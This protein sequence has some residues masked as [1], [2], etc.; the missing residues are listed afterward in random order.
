MRWELRQSATPG[1]L[2]TKSLTIL[3]ITDLRA[4]DKDILPRPDSR[5]FLSDLYLHHVGRM[6]NDLADRRLVIRS[7][8]SQ[9][10]FGDKEKTPWQP[11]FLLE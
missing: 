5:V 11:I 4:V 7:H 2:P 6:L 3:P 9:D 10:A 8:F 1:V